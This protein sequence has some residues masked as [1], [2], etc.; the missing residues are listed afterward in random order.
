MRSNLHYSGRALFRHF[1][2]NHRLTQ[3]Q[4]AVAL[5]ITVRHVKYVESGMKFP[6]AELIERF[7]ELAACYEWER[8]RARVGS[9]ST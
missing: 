3:R 1:R 9:W 4:L 2:R 7:K 8:E 6:S 5:G